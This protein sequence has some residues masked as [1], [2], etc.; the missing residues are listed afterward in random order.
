MTDLERLR[1]V[2]SHLGSCWR[3]DYE[4]MVLAAVQELQAARTY[5]L[6]LE[7]RDQ[8]LSEPYR[9]EEMVEEACRYCDEAQAAYR[10]V[11]APQDAGGGK[12]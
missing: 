11:T 10:R 1:A 4:E 7:I 3:K 12:P 6:W 5:I 9:H 2:G 8:R